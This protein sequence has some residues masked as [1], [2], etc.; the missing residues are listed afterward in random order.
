MVALDEGKKSAMAFG[1][2]II[3]DLA[4][5]SAAS[6]FSE[7]VVLLKSLFPYDTIALGPF[8]DFEDLSVRI[9]MIAPDH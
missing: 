5:F 1:D 6:F 4:I 9:D 3:A 8:M 7:W 2:L